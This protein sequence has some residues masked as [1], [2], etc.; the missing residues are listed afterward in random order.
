MNRIEIDQD[1]FRKVVEA[2]KHSISDDC[3]RPILKYILLRIKKNVLT[4]Y[5]VDGFRAS[6][7]QV[8]VGNVDCGEFECYIKPIKIPATKNAIEFCTIECDEKFAYVEV[9][10]EFGR[11]KYT[12]IQPD[13]KFIDIDKVYEGAYEHDREIFLNARY[14][15]EASKSIA[16]TSVKEGVCI[17]TKDDPTKP[18]ILRSQDES[19][20]IVNE[21][22]IL[23]IRRFLR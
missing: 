9:E 21:Q 7:V 10:T 5:S 13:S 11:L 22:L 2:V 3:S 14:L 12:F 17:Q 19:T 16:I 20:G 6:K 18:I 23:P 1:V 8:N 15:T 4:A